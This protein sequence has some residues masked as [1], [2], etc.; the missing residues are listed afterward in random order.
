MPY[1]PFL[2]TCTACQTRP[3]VP[4]KRL[5]TRTGCVAPEDPYELILIHRTGVHGTSPEALSKHSS[6][7][8]NTRPTTLSRCSEVL[9]RLVSS[10]QLSVFTQCMMAEPTA[11]FQV[12]TALDSRKDTA[13]P[14]KASAV[15][16]HNVSQ[17]ALAICVS[18]PETRGCATWPAGMTRLSDTF[19]SR[20]RA[21]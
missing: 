8:C 4:R 12:E 14:K 9:G 19:M 3:W 6:H 16:R 11:R 20:G 7:G 18:Q 17:N 1:A 10:L 13:R 5:E 2:L 21:R 15:C